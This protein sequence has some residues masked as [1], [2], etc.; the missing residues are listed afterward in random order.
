MFQTKRV[1]GIKKSK[2]L[3]KVASY[4]TKSFE[5]SFQKLVYSSYDFTF[6]KSIDSI[7]KIV[8]TSNIDIKSTLRFIQ[9][10]SDID[11]IEGLMDGVC[12]ITTNL[13][14]IENVLP[15]SYVEDYLLYN[16]IS[17]NALKDFF[18]LFNNRFYQLRY[19]FSKKLE[20]RHQSVPVQESVIGKIIKNLTTTTSRGQDPRVLPLQFQISA[21]NIFWHRARSAEHLRVLIKDFFE[22]PV[23][24]KEFIGKFIEAD[25]SEQTTIGTNLG[26]FNKVGYSAILGNKFWDS[27]KYLEIEIGPLEFAKYMQFLP[28][29]NSFDNAY[30][31][32][33]KLKE[34]VR[35]YVDSGI[36]VR[37]KFKLKPEILK[38]F[39]LNQTAR[40]NKEAFIPGICK[41]N[42]IFFT[43]DI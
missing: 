18:D 30:S 20:T 10:Y 24:I 2:K 41:N 14:G 4:R 25:Q 19:K 16:K 9:N 12:E 7:K 42:E 35:I 26:R 28:K 21:Q 37:L 33:R 1:F 36:S 8:P 23:R 5:T 43:E 15:D 34:L 11:N 31:H 29:H 38:S 3:Q 32:L 40:L 17:R 6:T 39:R 13:P 27:T 22:V